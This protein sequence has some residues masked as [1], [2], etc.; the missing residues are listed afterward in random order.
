MLIE[1]TS[2]MVQMNG[3]RGREALPAM[4]IDISCYVSGLADSTLVAI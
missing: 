3:P 4:Q 1:Q 2:D